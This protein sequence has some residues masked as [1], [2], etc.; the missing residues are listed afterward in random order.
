MKSKYSQRLS[1]KSRRYSDAFK[2]K[3]IS[4]IQKGLYSPWRAMQIYRIGGK[5]TVYKWL[6]KY[7]P[8]SVFIT[9]GDS[10]KKKKDV[11]TVDLQT[12]IRYLE[13]VVSDLSIEKKILE[14]IIDIANE[15]YGL[16]LKKSIGSASLNESIK[17][18]LK[19]SR[20]KQ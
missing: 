15:T 4:D 9:R 10:M 19:K 1:M 18:T 3:V 11:S 13:Q 6:A 16:D 17:K 14:A 8:D 2:R 5:N 12:R 7:A 20:S